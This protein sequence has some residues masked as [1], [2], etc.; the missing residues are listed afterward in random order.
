MSGAVRGTS[1]L[2]ASEPPEV[3]S[4]FRVLVSEHCEHCERTRAGNS[5]AVTVQIFAEPAVSATERSVN[6]DL[7]KKVRV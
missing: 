4:V 6:E 5:F 1:T 7:S 2:S 3:V